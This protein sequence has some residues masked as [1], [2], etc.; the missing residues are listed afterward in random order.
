LFC[1]GG[2]GGC[3]KIDKDID[4]ICLEREM[5]SDLERQEEDDEAEVASSDE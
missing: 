3:S 2:R 5:T 4:I 1:C